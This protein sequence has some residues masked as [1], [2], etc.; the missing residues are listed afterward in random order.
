MPHKVS[1]E[2]IVD[3]KSPVH[4]VI[5]YQEQILQELT[6]KW[7]KRFWAVSAP[8]IEA[9][10][11]PASRLSHLKELLEEAVG[12]GR[13]IES[14]LDIWRSNFGEAKASASLS[15]TLDALEGLTNDVANLEA[16]DF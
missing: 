1:V 16:T 3:T 14:D 2:F 9:V 12:Y 10:K 15:D 6:A 11:W 7:A 8:K 4:K 5:E 13:D